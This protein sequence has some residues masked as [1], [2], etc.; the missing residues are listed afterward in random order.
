MPEPR[1]DESRE[2][3]V[4]RCIPIVMDDGTAD[5]PD[6]AIAVCNS[7]Y[8]AGEKQAEFH[9]YTYNGVTCQ[10]TRRRSSDRDDKAYE[11]T[12][13][14]DDSERTVA[15]A[16][17]DMPMRRTNEEAREAFNARHSCDEKTDPFAAG[18]WS[19]Y[20]WNH[21][22][23]KGATMTRQ[24]EH[25]TFELKIESVEG[26]TV[27]GYAAIFGNVDQGGDVIHQG[28]FAKT[29]VERGHKVKFLWQHDTTEP[30]GR[31]I[32]MAEDEV[33]LRFKAIISDTQRGRDA[34]ALL[35][36]GAIDGMSIGYDAIPGGTDY[37]KQEDGGETVRHLREIRLWEI[38]LVTFPM[39]ESAGVTSL[40]EKNEG[41]QPEQR[42]VGRAISAANERRILGVIDGI[43]SALDE[44][45]DLIGMLDEEQEEEPEEEMDDDEKSNAPERAAM[46]TEAGPQNAP[47]SDEWM[48][49]RIDTYL[50][51]LEV[52]NE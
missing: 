49:D 9:R 29:L 21:P 30:I 15:Y 33:G 46:E 38:S 6:Q 44:L 18:F 45:R 10:A 26:R 39:N 43:D 4:E 1:E 27:E 23:E 2:E 52:S 40:K 22:D 11:R 48:V 13:R 47:T 36:D 35:S 17:P 16:D 32:E 8:E 51:E 19:C 12:V 31:V 25:K 50:L 7:M 37:S 41:G 24:M 20:D 3:F 34:L 5:T 28:A 42:K 14:Y